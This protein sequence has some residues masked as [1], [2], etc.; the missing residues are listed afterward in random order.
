MASQSF[1]IFKPRYPEFISVLKQ[2]LALVKDHDPHNNP[3]GQLAIQT[4]NPDSND[5]QDG[6]GSGKSTPEYEQTY[7]FLQHGLVGTPLDRYL[8]WL[9][10]DVFRTR[11]MLSKPKSCYS[12]HRDFTPRLHLPLITNEQCKFLFTEPEQLIHMPADGRTYW[13]D[14]RVN[15]TFL[16]GSTDDRYHL[17]M[18]VKE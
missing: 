16:N 12:I 14:T 15:H 4:Q 7:K 8:S 9:G 18:V 10:V 3:H 5:W 17:V 2:C 13:V 11:L 1:K 6:I